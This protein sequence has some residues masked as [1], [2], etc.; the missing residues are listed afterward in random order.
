M[1]DDINV[2][3]FTASPELQSKLDSLDDNL[4][5]VTKDLKEEKDEEPVAEAEKS[6]EEENEAVDET[7]KSKEDVESEET[8]ET[9]GYTIDEGEE[10]DDE[11][12]EPTTSTQAKPNQL[13]AEQQYVLDNIATFKVRGTVPGSDKVESFDVYTIEQLPPGFKYESETELALAMK[14]DNTNEQRAEILLNNFRTQETS[15]AAQEFKVREDNA[16]RQD[17]GNLQREGLLP[18][19]T[20]EPNAKD[21]DS[22]PAVELVNNILKFKEDTNQ[23]YLDEYNA[24]RPYKH[25]G[26]EEAFRMYKYQNPDKVD[27]ELQKEDAARQAL[28]KRTS[29]AKG[30]SSQETPRQRARAGMTSRDLDNLIDSLDW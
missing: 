24:G 14:R 16:D 3:G 5:P 7:E 10:D 28:A 26:F 22:D 2:P 20:K 1:A 19:F 11:E 23:R 21:F 6:S 12:P 9:E 13:T 25:I 30:T 8:A 18:K 15:K 4:E 27:T 17:I 29:K